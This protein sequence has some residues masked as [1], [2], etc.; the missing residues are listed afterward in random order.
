[1][2]GQVHP[3]RQRRTMQRLLCQVCAGS[4]D[5][6]ADGVLWLLKDHR[7]DWPNWP[8]GMGVTEPPIC[9]SC[10][11][12]STR[13]CPALRKGAVAIRANSFVVAGVYGTLYR[14]SG[15]RPVPTGDVSVMF[16]DP[17]ARWLRAACLVRRLREC[18]IVPLA[19]LVKA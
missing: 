2:F 3:A 6:T 19:D 16:E 9:L 18:E 12:V 11:E 1:M 10:V 7:E 14:R 15:L 17:A 13:L 5:Q 8:D 4:A